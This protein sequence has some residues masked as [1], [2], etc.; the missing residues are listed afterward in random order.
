MNNKKR[1]TVYRSRRTRKAGF[2]SSKAVMPTVVTIAAAGL[3][4]IGGYSI[5]KPIVNGGDAP[6]S[7]DQVSDENLAAENS[8]DE[9]AVTTT[10]T[11]NVVMVNGGT[12]VTTT[13]TTTG[14]P[15]AAED[16]EINI[17]N[18]GGSGQ[19]L[20]P[21]GGSSGS[22]A[23]GNTGSTG[24]SSGDSGSSGSDNSGSGSSSGGSSVSASAGVYKTVEC[25]VRLPESAVTDE[26]SLRAMLQNVKSKYPDAGAV[27]IPMKLSGGSLTFDSEAAGSAAWAVCKGS[28]TAAE[29]A[30]IVNEEGFQAFASCSLL[31]DHIYADT[32]RDASYKVEKNGVLT[33]DRWLDNTVANG[34]KSWL[35]PN[36]SATVSYLESLVEELSDGGFSAILCSGFTYPDFSPLDEPYLNPDI[37]A[38]EAAPMIELANSLSAAVSGSADIVLD[39]SAYYAMNGLE[40]VYEPSELDVSYALLNTSASEAGTASSWAQSNSGDI[41]VSISYTDGNGSGHRVV[42]Y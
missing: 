6:A 35:D 30:S 40:P 16:E 32:Y 4:C 34:G 41:S 42:T 26:A 29:I 1:N 19:D 37:F 20:P 27:V 25:T 5:A 14:D 28:M 33:G 21:A 39:L 22:D 11:T 3:L 7:G 13:A 15:E 8:Q 17:G 12:T 9:N 38:K 36:S 23:S 31:D 2:S 10:V 18:T 24:S